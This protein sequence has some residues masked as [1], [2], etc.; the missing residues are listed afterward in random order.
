M[1]P[2]KNRLKQTSDLKRVLK[3]GKA[4]KE[5]L[6]ILKII[7]NDKAAVRVGFIVSLKVA[8]KATLRNKIKRMLRSL[9]LAKL[10]EMKASA[11]MVLIALPGLEKESRQLVK[12][13]ISKL[14]LKAKIIDG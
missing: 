8:K 3:K 4:F 2:K 10:K 11:D 5:N 9:V 7:N 13:S 6:L 14:F 1:L 12:D